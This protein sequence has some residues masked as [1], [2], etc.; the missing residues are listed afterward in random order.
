MLDLD[1]AEYGNQAMQHMLSGGDE[2]GLSSTM[3]AEIRAAFDKTTEK[4]KKG[5][6]TSTATL[7][8]GA[9]DTRASRAA[10]IMTQ[11]S[12][13]VGELRDDFRT[14]HATVKS[15]RYL[16]KE[17]EKHMI[18]I[19]AWRA[20]HGKL[21]QAVYEAA[22]PDQKGAIVLCASFN[23]AIVAYQPIDFS[24]AHKE[25]DFSWTQ[26]SDAQALAQAATKNPSLWKVIFNPEEDKGYAKVA[27]STAVLGSPTMLKLAPHVL[28]EGAAEKTPT[29]LDHAVSKAALTAGDDAISPDQV[30]ALLPNLTSEH[31]TH[32]AVFKAVSLLVKNQSSSLTSTAFELWLN[33]APKNH[34]QRA[35]LIED[36]ENAK[37]R[38]WALALMRSPPES[39]GAALLNEMKEQL[40]ASR[41]HPDTVLPALQA[42]LG[43]RFGFSFSTEGVAWGNASLTRMWK[44][45][46]EL[47][48]D[49]VDRVSE[50]VREGKI[51]D[52]VKGTYQRSNQKIGLSFNE[53]QIGRDDNNLG[54]SKTLDVDKKRSN[55]DR[56]DHA[57]RHEVGHAVDRQTNIMVNKGAKEEFGGWKEYGGKTVL[58]DMLSDAKET[59]LF[60]EAWDKLE[61]A[62]TKKSDVGERMDR[63]VT[64]RTKW[65]DIETKLLDRDT[66]G[67]DLTK[68]LDASKV[69]K[70]IESSEGGQHWK[71]PAPEVG[72]HIYGYQK[73]SGGWLRYSSNARKNRKLSA[74]QFMA[75]SE[76]FAEAYAFY[77][78]EKDAQD[79]YGKLVTD[80]DPF[81][82]KWLDENV[83]ESEDG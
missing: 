16:D 19:E 81:I 48:P 7:K 69:K 39:G 63:A 21:M 73:N 5:K 41:S 8:T 70:I 65:A 27:P 35:F 15:D 68:K 25:V 72:D 31:L 74:H 83:G 14:S 45:L 44:V 9:S 49:Q 37:T 71:N 58:T 53:A 40:S 59:T 30:K 17:K 13:N 42:V 26:P 78:D 60:E 82:K 51:E 2:G 80:K 79:N 50:M 61:K 43:V 23:S 32:A 77:F 33:K 11:L 67:T 38:T 10:N 6:K 47:P 52:G 66:L 24:N 62:D 3:K 18:P 28:P 56:F 1:Q 20:E 36:C 75:P 4:S 29:W 55:P 57:L 46:K 22:K 34:E 64:A 12:L 76:W 54:D